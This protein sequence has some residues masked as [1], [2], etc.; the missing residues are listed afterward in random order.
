MV[1]KKLTAAVR[2]GLQRKADEHNEKYGDT[3][4]KRTSAR[5]LG[6]VF[7][8]GVGAYRTNPQSVRPNVTGPEQWAYARVNAFLYALRTG[9]FRGGKFDTDLLPSSHPM[10]TKKNITK[11]SYKPTEAMVAAA[12]RGLKLRAEQPPSRRGGTAVGISRARDIINGKEMPASTVLRM[13][14]FFARHSVNPKDAWDPS[15]PDYPAKSLQAHLLWGGD[16]GKAWSTRIRNQIIREREKGME[17]DIDKAMGPMKHLLMAYNEMM[18]YNFDG[19]KELRQDVMEIIHALEMQ[20]AGEPMQEVRTGYGYDEEEKLFYDYD[21]AIVEREGQYCVTSANGNRNF[22]CYGSMEAAER[23]LSQIE[24][25]SEKLKSM[26]T[27]S[28]E[29]ALDKSFIDDEDGYIEAALEC[30]ADELDMRKGSFNESGL[31]PIVKQEQRYT[32]GPVYVPNLEDAHGETIDADTLQ[33]AIWDWVRKG[34]RNIYLQ[35][36]EK[37]AGEMVE[38]L[39]WPMEI[40]TSLIVPNQGVTKY[41]F[42][43]DT[44]FMGVIWEDWAWDLVKAGKL[45]GYSIG[46]QAARVEVELPEDSLIV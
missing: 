13:F 46:G 39:T 5:T 21:K 10:S 17:G 37:V 45:R 7:N 16:A 42:P 9:R 34:D 44:P 27:E 29:I 26:D 14:S 18:P 3:P 11:A 33:K 25:F 2:A 41:T 36:S 28:L 4:S 12:R 23:R 20:I 30:I 38:I 6:A 31:T 32:M 19:A 24:R 1:E 8:R 43:A 15:H 40:E 22:G 35:H